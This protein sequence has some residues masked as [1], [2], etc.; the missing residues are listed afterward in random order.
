MSDPRSRT[1]HSNKVLSELEKGKEMIKAEANNGMVSLEMGGLCTEWAVEVLSIITA[2]YSGF[3]ET[4]K[5]AGDRLLGA[6]SEAIREGTI[7][8][9]SK[10]T[11]SGEV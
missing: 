7:Q 9:W 10:V 8:E 4:E 1:K 11:G 6:I 2:T 5:G 3:E